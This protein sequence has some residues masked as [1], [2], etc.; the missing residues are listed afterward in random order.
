VRYLFLI[1]PLLLL[2]SCAEEE[3]KEGEHLDA[4]SDT[5]IVKEIKTEKLQ[6][7]YYPDLNHLNKKLFP[8]K[9]A[10]EF[11]SFSYRGDSLPHLNPNRERFSGIE[12]YYCD[13]TY[14]SKFDALVF[15]IDE[16]G[17]CGAFQYLKTT[18]KKDSVISQVPL[19]VDCGWENGS[20]SSQ[21][22]F[23]NDS[24][25]TVYTNI[26]GRAIIK[27]DY[28][29]YWDYIDKIEEYKILSNGV[30]VKTLEEST[31]K[32]VPDSIHYKY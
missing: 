17:D 26:M 7:T 5:I 13:I 22:K 9:G 14:S 12:L 8:C 32:L 3:N 16:G 31:Q 30:I 29:P 23:I 28:Q 18:N 20:E 24:T 15:I 6:M 4:V 11:A 1:I 10:L 19:V 21:A 2:C 27:S 25:F